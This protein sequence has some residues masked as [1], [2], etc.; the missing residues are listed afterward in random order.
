MA[1]D[2]Q[3]HNRQAD[4][5]E[6]GNKKL[7]T[8]LWTFLRQHRQMPRVNVKVTQMTAESRTIHQVP[9]CPVC[10]RAFISSPD[11]RF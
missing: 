7:E 1:G 3:R 10:S 4:E 9:S 5:T 6:T 2:M 8:H 11:S